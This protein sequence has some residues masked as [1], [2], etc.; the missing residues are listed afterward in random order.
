MPVQTWHVGDAPVPDLNMVLQVSVRGPITHQ[1]W[2]DVACST[3]P[4][5]TNAISRTQ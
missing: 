3:I 4:A 1:P 5:A 2:F